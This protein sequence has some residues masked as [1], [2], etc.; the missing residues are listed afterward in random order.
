MSASIPPPEGPE[1]LPVLPLRNSVLFPASVVPVNVGRARSVRLIEESFGRDRPTVAVVAQRASETED[2][3]FEQVFT[4]GTVARVLKVIRLSSGNYSVVLQGI[5]RMQI[6]EPVSRQPFMRARVQ[7]IDEPPLKDPELNSLVIQLREGARKLLELLPHPPRETVTVLDNIQDAG[8]LAD[9]V[10]SS[11]PVTTLQKQEVLEVLDVHARIRRVLEL[12]LRQSQVYRVKKEISTMVQEEMSKSQ[13]EILLRQQMKS[14]KKELGE[15]DDDDEIENLRDKLARADLTIE[16][17]RAAK[18]QLSRMRSMSPNGAEFQ[19]ARN[20]VEWISDLPWGRTTP[21]RLDV[22]E[23]RRV[24]DEDHHGLEK[25]KKRIVE[26]IAVRRLKSDIKGPILCF[27]GPPGVGKTSLAKSIARATGRNFTRVALG[28]V[29][30]EAE[31]RGHRRTYVG[32]YPGRIVGAMKAAAARNPVMLLDEVDKLAS[33]GR[34]DPGAALLEVLDPEQNST[35]TDHYLEIPLDL[36]QVL[37]I[38]TANRK[39]TIPRA[40]LDRMEVI[41]LAGYT[42]EEKVAIA[43]GFLIPKQMSD[44][45][46]SPGRLD[47]TLE[48]ID[49]LVD[50][51]TREAG[52]RNL[53]QKVAALCRAVAVRLAE[54]EDVKQLATEAWVK[55]ALGAPRFDKSVAERVGRPGVATGL[56]WTPAGGQLMF[57]E[58]SQMPGKGQLHMTGKIGDVM[59]ESVAAAMTYLRARPEQLGLPFDFLDRIDVHLHLP[60]GGFPKDG[61]SAGIPIFV[62]LS[63]ML[64]KLKVR[65]D[66]GMTG[67]ITLRGAVL[68]V[69]GIKEK[70]L[71]A[72][73]AGLTHIILPK[74]NE[75]DVEEVPEV[76]R[77]GLTFHYVNKVDEILAF[78]L[79]L[80][81]GPSGRSSERPA[82]PPPS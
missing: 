47:F 27:V 20:Y 5:S 42:R 73:R 75:P 13:R 41:D 26:Y 18:K 52:V 65:P 51:Y 19:V 61:P 64:T 15:G 44:H 67:E 81:S 72:H 29:Q 25:I 59:K 46:L 16:A 22:A 82:A 56:A 76:I 4:L 40:L 74:R 77:K 57:I 2:P 24:L 7:R 45:G 49:A 66:V 68:P 11:L 69:T 63:S 1:I 39:D 9:L 54:G 8:S 3:E 43:K 12:V 36:S 33:D 14:I 37:F 28:G 71:A 30:D 55:E 78:A 48:A 58:A 10:A 60:G 23:A 53:E 21:D 38:A 35:F 50:Y 31:I 70:A 79:D 6:L 32:A 17:D 80:E 62:A 34:G